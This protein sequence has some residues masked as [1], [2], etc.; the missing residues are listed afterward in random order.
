MNDFES[1]GDNNKNG[2]LWSDWTRTP[3]ERDLTRM[4]CWDP[5]E[6]GVQK[7]NWPER[8]LVVLD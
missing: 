3:S 6:D 4:V 8:Q 7:P 2:K 5:S 1:I